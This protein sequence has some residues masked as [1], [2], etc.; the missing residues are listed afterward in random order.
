[1]N[2]TRTM[3]EA[4]IFACGAAMWFLLLASAAD[5]ATIDAAATLVEWVLALK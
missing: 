3:A 4:S 2:T 1:M 5:A